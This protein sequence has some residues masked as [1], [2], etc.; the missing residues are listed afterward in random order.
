MFSARLNRIR[1][2]LAVRLA[3]WFAGMFIFGLGILFGLSYLLLSSS[4]K[5]REQETILLQLDVYRAEYEKSRSAV[6][7]ARLLDGEQGGEENTYIVRF[8]APDDRTVFTRTPPQWNGAIA[9]RLETIPVSNEPR[10]LTL[11]DDGREIEV[12]TSRLRD[13]SILQVGMETAARRETLSLFRQVFLL[14]ALPVLTLGI[15]GGAFAAV[16]GIRPLKSLAETV[17]SIIETG[18]V[19]ARV[20][21]TSATD[22]IG[23]LVAEFNEMLGRIDTLIAGMRE[24]LDNVAHDLRTPLT[25]LRGIAEL[26]IQSENPESCR[27]ALGT[28]LE[29]TEQIQVMLKTLMDISEAE[30][31]AMR[32]TLAT[33]SLR[34]VVGQV[35]DL[36]EFLAEEKDISISTD[37]PD[38][39]ILTADRV[40]LKQVLA[41]LL[42]NAVKY[43]P[44]RGTVS[45]TASVR[46]QSVVIEVRDSGAGIADEDL[47]RIFERLYRAD[48]SRSQRGLGLGLSLVRAV[49]RAH[50]GEVEV[51]SVYG[52]GTTFTVE[53]PLNHPLPA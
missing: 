31:G 33:V 39:L 45:V 35:V 30:T 41:N 40:R 3:A 53:L 24:S 46:G 27:D 52:Q 15:A 19:G 22:E 20:Q 13:G 32:L 37:I 28:C 9:R 48:K 25:R 42:D 14:T 43:T 38:E 11:S 44:D 1:H 5:Q 50:H 12:A 4:I 23:V 18:D 8:A 29:E 51:R 6:D 34:E 17:R 7:L 2:S 16:R 21:P 47:P 10:W 36:Y 26:A 49:I